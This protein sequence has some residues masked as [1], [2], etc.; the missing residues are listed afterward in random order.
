[1]VQSG[2]DHPRCYALKGRPEAE[3]SDA[4]ITGTVS[5]FSR[6]ASV[7][8]DPG[9]TYSYVLSCFTSYLVVPRDS[10]SAPVYVSTP[11]W[12]SIIVDRVYRSCMVIISGLETSVDLLL[13]DMVDF[14]VIMMMDWLS[15]YHAILDYHAKTVT[16]A[17]PGSP[18]LEWRG[19][20]G[21]ST[22]RVISYMK[23]QNLPGMPPDRDIDLCIDLV[24]D[25]QP[26]SIPPYCMA[27]LELN[28]LKEQLQDLLDKGFI[29]PSVSLWGANV[30]CKEEGWINEDVHRLSTVEQSHHQ[31]QVSIAED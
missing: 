28:E 18:R 7:L 29:I 10:L 24:P 3:S 30:V 2:G 12:D 4:V 15:P 14:D 25:T 31:E 27:P 6:D 1:M 22:S 9:S 11:V 26:I 23:A 19:T 17:L 21:H 20:L 13:L 5:V 8:F 16:F